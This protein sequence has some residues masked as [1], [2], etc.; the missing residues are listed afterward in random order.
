MKLLEKMPLGSPLCRGLV[1]ATM[2][3][4]R[5]G[6]E[7][8]GAKSTTT[9]EKAAR[10]RPKTKQPKST[11]GVAAQAMLGRPLLTLRWRIGRRSRTSQAPLAHCAA[12]AR[13]PLVQSA[14]F[15]SLCA[16]DLRLGH[17]RLAP[18]VNPTRHRSSTPPRSRQVV[19]EMWTACRE[20]DL[21]HRWRPL[22]RTPRKCLASLCTGPEPTSVGS[23]RRL[24]ASGR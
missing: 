1:Y 14:R 7:G 15:R 17:P 16:L 9:A 21:P 12:A 18:P 20:P 11:V 19:E 24:P 4:R 3:C 23:G 5:S 8:A 22:G 6:K 13:P 10:K 2:L